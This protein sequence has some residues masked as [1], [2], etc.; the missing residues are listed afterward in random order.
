MCER[1]SLLDHGQC[2]ADKD[3]SFSQRQMVSVEEKF[4]E[5]LPLVCNKINLILFF[6]GNIQKYITRSVKFSFRLMALTTVNRFLNS[7]LR[8]QGATS[9][10][11]MEYLTCPHMPSIDDG[12]LGGNRNLNL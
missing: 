7:L 2:T 11:R 10:I 9:T 12:K 8:H 5:T 1:Q 6:V 4:I 3:F